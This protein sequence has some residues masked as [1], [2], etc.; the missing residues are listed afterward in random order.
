MARIPPPSLTGKAASLL[1]ANLS[2]PEYEF[3]TILLGNAVT[4]QSLLSS[5][6]KQQLD[7]EDG[8]LDANGEPIKSLSP[9]SLARITRSA[10]GTVKEVYEIL[11]LKGRMEDRKGSGSKHITARIGIRHADGTEAVATVDVER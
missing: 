4:A 11:E 9:D 3:F 5:A 2:R 6:L 8:A 1:P 7:A 10:L